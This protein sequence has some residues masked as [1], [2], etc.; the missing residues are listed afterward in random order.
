MSWASSWSPG[1]SAITYTHVRESSADLFVLYPASG[2]PFRLTDHRADEL[3][4]RW[5][6]DGGKI[7]FLSDRGSGTDIYWIS[8]TG[9]PETK[10]AE[11]YIP[12]MEQV[13]S[14]IFILGAQPWS[15][16]GQELLFSRSHPDGEVAIWK[17]NLATGEETQLT[18]PEPGVE[19]LAASWSFDGDGIVFARGRGG[20]SGL[21]WQ[22]TGGRAELLIAEEY[23]AISPVW[24]MDGRRVVFSSTRGGPFNL[25]E[26]DVGSRQMRQITTSPGLDFMASIGR[27]GRLAYT[28][29]AHQTDLYWMD[30]DAPRRDHERLTSF[31]LDNFA[32]KVAPDGNAI[33]YHSNHRRGDYEI[34]M[35]ERET[36]VNRQLTDNPATDVMPDWSPDGSEVAFVS[37]REGSF[38]L[39]LLN[40]G[41]PA[42]RRLTDQDIQVKGPM[43][44]AN[45]IRWSPDGDA[46]GYVAAT[47]EG[48][49]LW[50]VSPEGG[51]ARPTGLR[52]VL[53]FDWYRDGSHVV[54]TR[55][56]PG[57]VGVDLVGAELETEREVVLLTGSI[58][59]L[60]AARD[61]S[62]VAF[63][64]SESHYNM[65]LH[66][67][68]LEAG[69]GGL[70]RAIG[71]PEQITFGNG[72]W[73]VHHGDWSPDG[74]F[75][76]YTRDTD[77]GEI[78]LVENY[79]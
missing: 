50:L 31:T 11:T 3:N 2:D 71:E 78:Y 72:A 9:G 26:I 1:G 73:H 44:H 36:G 74:R 40:V 57:G 13:W 25:W 54:Y 70:P 35:L 21:W 41:Q 49:A 6:P 62:A 4:P 19:D 79:R 38:Q 24:T 63:L 68:R 53:S 15:R 43:V 10:L 22:P 76:V 61:G 27:D 52:G 59:E 29:F 17:I 46:I 12:F 56:A 18:H 55:K 75:I 66:R 45:T 48:M 77:R 5:S 69:P 16:D 34:W 42:V 8:P 64:L 37:D 60:T 20:Q 47:S 23:P 33:V 51:D 39:W 30:V 7:A 67:L 58:A 65:D 28:Q 14:W 32:A